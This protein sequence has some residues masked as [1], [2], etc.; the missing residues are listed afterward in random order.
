MKNLTKFELVNINGGHDDCG[1]MP[2]SGTCTGS[3]NIGHFVGRVIGGAIKDT[4]EIFSGL[5]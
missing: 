1:G 4:K 2:A 3:Y 5:F